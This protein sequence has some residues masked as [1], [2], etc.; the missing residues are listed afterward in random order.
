[1]KWG[2][3]PPKKAEAICVGIRHSGGSRNPGSLKL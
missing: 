1:M 3:L 2:L